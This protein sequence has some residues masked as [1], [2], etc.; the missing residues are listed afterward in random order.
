MSKPLDAFIIHHST[1]S[2]LFNELKDHLLINQQESLLEPWWRAVRIR[3]LHADMIQGG[4]ER[5]AKIG[6]QIDSAQ[7]IL[8]LISSGFLND[9]ECSA[10]LA[11]ALARRHEALVVP[12]LVR[13]CDWEPVLGDLRSL[14]LPA[15]GE[16]IKSSRDR[17]DA[18]TTAIRELRAKLDLWRGEEVAGL[19][20][21]PDGQVSNRWRVHLAESE[22]VSQPLLALIPSLPEGEW[23]ERPEFRSLL[24]TLLKDQSKPLIL[25]G[26]PGSGK[27]ALFARLAAEL[28]RRGDAVLAIRADQLPREI[29]SSE[30][31]QR[32][33][34]LSASPGR[35][36]SILASQLPTVLLIDQLDALC[37][38]VDAH[39]QRLSVLLDLVAE[40]KGISGLRVVLSCRDFELR[41]DHRLRRLQAE[42]IQLELPSVSE[43]KRVLQGRGI[44]PLALQKS[45]LEALRVPQHLMTFLALPKGKEQTSAFETYQQMLEALWQE[46]IVGGEGGQERERVLVAIAAHMADEE[47]LQ[48]PLAKFGGRHRPQ[49]DQLQG[50]GILRQEGIKIEFTHQTWFAF[51]RARS[52][53][54][55]EERLCD[56]V[57]QRGGSLFVRATL[58][59]ALVNLREASPGRYRSELDALCKMPELRTHLRAL[60]LEFLGQLDEPRD[61]EAAILLPTLKGEEF[62]R[63]VAL[64]AVAGSRGWFRRLADRHL[65]RLMSGLHAAEVWG[66]LARAWPFARERVL[67]L[68][69]RYWVRDPAR[70]PLVLATLRE[71]RV[72]DERAVEVVLEVITHQPTASEQTKLG[73]GLI[74]GNIAA[75]NPVMALQVVRAVLDQ[76]LQIC[77]ATPEEGQQKSWPSRRYEELLENRHNLHG[78]IELAQN[79]PGPFLDQL[80]PW[81]VDVLGKLAGPDRNVFFGYR[82]DSVMY[83]WRR[84][85]SG[86]IDEI[87][88]AVRIAV[89]GLARQDADR[90]VGFVKQ[91]ES[92]DLLTVHRLLAAGLKIVAPYRTAAVVEYLLGDQRRLIL[93]DHQDYLYATCELL[94]AISPYLGLEE[95]RRL[96]RAMLRSYRYSE[97]RNTDQ[98][99]WRFHRQ[100]SNRL[101]R[102]RLLRTLADCQHLSP[103]G[104]RLVD[105]E[106][107]ALESLDSV[108]SLS[109]QGF[110]EVKSPMLA[111]QMLKAKDEDL[112]SFLQELPDS[113]EWQHPSRS[114]VGGSIQ[115]SRELAE[116]AKADPERVLRIIPHLEPSSHARPVAHAVEA[117][118]ESSTGRPLEEIEALLFSLEQRG[119]ASEDYH[120][121]AAGAFDK[122]TR[123]GAGLSDRACHLLE[124]WLKDVSPEPEEAQSKSPER[125]RSI[126]WSNRGFNALPHGNFTI[127]RAL[128]NGYMR[129]D[130]ADVDLLLDVLGRHLVRHEQVKTWRALLSYLGYVQR[131]ERMERFV[132]RLF[133]KFPS[134]RDCVDGAYLIGRMCCWGSSNVLHGW[135]HAMRQSCWRDGAQAYGELLVLLAVCRP[136]LAWVRE[137]LERSL[138]SDAVEADR[139]RIQ[140][141]LVY[142]AVHLWSEQEGRELSTEVLLRLLPQASADMSSAIMGVFAYGSA[143]P[144]DDSTIRLLDSLLEHPFMLA[145]SV[146]HGFASC[147]QEL[148]AEE[149]DRVLKLCNTLLDQRTAEGTHK[150]GLAEEDL[151][152][153]TVTLQRL[154]GY[155]E[156]GLE[157]FERLLVM[158]L[159][160]ARETL[161][162]LDATPQLEGRARRRA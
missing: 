103:E 21:G 99:K 157:L 122:L 50:A 116:V 89:E 6:N 60:V 76:Q 61:E 126:L 75:E 117:L 78:L 133:E 155:R 27:S 161:R 156:Q 92:S 87:P 100:R 93:G 158:G 54:I 115:A 48:A 107:R 124:S 3:W 56:Y 26:G 143:L 53:I 69:E 58:W 28:Q 62:L 17:D 102:L 131:S 33:L 144:A 59:S 140:L 9:R 150:L 84:R 36:L 85:E 109:M 12:I 43:V 34:N 35:V 5:P 10:W 90:F 152:S 11:R 68:L 8:P 20:S 119:F 154:P 141:G 146:P 31:L 151:I 18:W 30:K 142:A 138:R 118:A 63:R 94:E 129:R 162:E 96:E 45:F 15:N 136:E 14:L 82:D 7:L 106:E 66:T 159:Y 105:Q 19:T 65:P 2:P 113:T 51:T 22:R 160:G 95:E 145:A 110:S 114:M 4:E 47:E 52:F 112:L 121:H 135:F 40:V 77:H 120:E 79:A 13:S 130:P 128:V 70:G 88:E 74:V 67:D 49:L 16:A 123:R 86:P 24:D 25:L 83:G 104:H 149:P 38:L 44:E 55:G 111:P 29:D 147:I 97:E 108:R 32:W 46:R 72:W 37:D 23:L 137:E 98:V 1:D 148:C 64:G 41:H 73:I 91:W 139:E 153:I 71:L 42:Q 127:L 132:S 134:V 80:W 81:V 57:R 101:H 125:P 39:T